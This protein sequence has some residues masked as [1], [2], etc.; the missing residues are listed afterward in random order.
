MFA[1]CNIIFMVLSLGIAFWAKEAV[2]PNLLVATP[3]PVV[4]DLIRDWEAVPF[5]SIAMREG[6]CTLDGEEP[7]F[8][9]AWDGTERG[10]ETEEGA[11]AA[12][13]DT[14]KDDGNK[15]AD[16]TEVPA[17]APIRQ[18]AGANGRTI[19]GTR[20]G[21]S[22]GDV[23]R[24]DPATSACPEGTAACSAS[25]SPENTVCY[26]AAEHAT[27]CPITS[28]LVVDIRGKAAL[29]AEYTDV[30]TIEDGVSYLA[31]SRTVDSLPLSL[32][33]V[34]AEA[35]CRDAEKVRQEQT[36]WYPLELGRERET[37]EAAD[38]DPRYD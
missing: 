11:N 31:Y 13:R 20:G 18:A 10:C 2:E 16:C 23:T 7:V 6:G 3:L 29:G 17:V 27:S 24:V 34:G 26:P 15:L 12:P 1:T 19:C 37:C 33:H 38:A 22:F 30:L 32:T 5:T 21:E 35:P 9:R 25:T 8:V 4:K 14:W 28:I 36:S